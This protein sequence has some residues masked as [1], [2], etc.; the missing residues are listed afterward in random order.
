MRGS[1]ITTH[2]TSNINTV[3]VCVCVCVCVRVVRVVMYHVQ[4]IVTL[5]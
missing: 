5:E 4:F 2:F 3:C 1:M